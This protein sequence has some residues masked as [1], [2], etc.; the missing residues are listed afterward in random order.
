MPDLINNCMF[1]LKKL[2]NVF[3]CLIK[4]LVSLPFVNLN[5]F[6]NNKSIGNNK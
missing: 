3:K 5:A 1:D 2:K 4:V 6:S